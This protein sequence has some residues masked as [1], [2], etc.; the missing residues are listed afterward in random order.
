MAL[1]DML[2]DEHNLVTPLDW[3]T[4]KDDYLAKNRPVLWRDNNGWPADQNDNYP[5]DR[6]NQAT[7]K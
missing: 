2:Y 1:N 4:L 6:A 5:E 3:P 7:Q